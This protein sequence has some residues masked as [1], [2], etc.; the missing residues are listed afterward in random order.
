MSWFFKIFN[1]NKKENSSEKS[2]K[3]EEEKNVSVESREKRSVDKSKGKKKAKK[4]REKKKKS[5]PKPSGEREVVS[6]KKEAKPE[7]PDMEKVVEVS[8]V[9]GDTT[10][11]LEEPEVK[12]E[13]SEEEFPP[14]EF[15]E[16]KKKK[17]KD[18]LEVYKDVYAVM[19]NT[20]WDISWMILKRPPEIADDAQLLESYDLLNGEYQVE[21]YLYEGQG[22]YILSEKEVSPYLIDLT[23]VVGEVIRRL[24]LDI[25]EGKLMDTIEYVL[26]ILELEID[27]DTRKQVHHYLYKLTNPYQI[28][29]PLFADESVEEI[30][31]PDVNY[32]VFVRHRRYPD[33]Q[34][35]RTNISFPNEDTLNSYVQRLALVS[36]KSISPS[37]PYVECRAPDGSRLTLVYGEEVSGGPSITVRKYPEEPWTIVKLIAV[38]AISVEAAAY[39]W[40]LHEAKGVIFVSGAMATG[41]TT[42]LN[43]LLL[44]TD[45]RR[46]I[47]TLEE[48]PELNLPH[49]LWQRMYTREIPFYSQL[50]PVTLWDLAIWSLR[51]RGDYVVIGEARGEE[52]TALVQQSLFGTGALTT[53][54]ATSPQDLINRL[55]SPPLN[56]PEHWI[57]SIWAIVQLR[58]IGGWRGVTDVV[59]IDKDGHLVQV[60]QRESKKDT[61]K[62]VTDPAGTYRI[63]LAGTLL[64]LGEKVR[65][66][67][68][69]RVEFLKDMLNKRIY[70]YKDLAR[71]LVKYYAEKSVIE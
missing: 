1:K 19:K 47:V 3:K 58:N 11:V 30:T 15:E 41:K 5:K 32:E 36:G 59:E 10:T 34:W 69:N 37:N 6:K 20:L 64:I 8:E 61:L 29:Y 65:D 26:N 54:H 42:M 24:G 12:P 31:I 40:L 67:Y 49:P 56:L 14:E 52:V 45:P 38:D 33:L 35:L 2:S 43:A 71:E 44:L 68:H 18:K 66:E 48:T 62:A 27:E 46:K 51:S 17:K 57:P 28:L 22:Y 50:K 16:P 23:N 4:T 70:K 7:A 63:R 55:I 53:I 9:G 25:S 39:L 60:F 21:L 13:E